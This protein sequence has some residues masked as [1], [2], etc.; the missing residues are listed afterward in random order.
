MQNGLENGVCVNFRLLSKSSNWTI[1]SDVIHLNLAGTHV[2]VVNS[3]EAAFELFEKRS[4]IYSD[5]VR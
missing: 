2:L 1:D 3:R 5:R 4:A